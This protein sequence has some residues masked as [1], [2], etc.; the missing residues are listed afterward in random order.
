MAE[1]FVHET[2]C[3]KYWVMELRTMGALNLYRILCSSSRTRTYNN[4]SIT[5]LLKE[6]DH[7]HPF[8]AGGNEMAEMLIFI[9]SSIHCTSEVSTTMLLQ[10]SSDPIQRKIAVWV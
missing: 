8:I 10:I 2:Y 5:E 9:V 6:M 4:N 1:H 7:T 3:H